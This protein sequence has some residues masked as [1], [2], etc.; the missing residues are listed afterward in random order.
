VLNPLTIF[1]MLWSVITKPEFKVLLTNVDYVQIYND[2]QDLIIV[3][4]QNP[5]NQPDTQ[6][7]TN[8]PNPQPPSAQG[9]VVALKHLSPESILT[10]HE[11][12]LSL[13]IYVDK[14]GKQKIKEA[15]K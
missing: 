13:T 15:L 5:S 9:C 11:K 3:F 14:L 1:K 2:V 6:P 7:P 8:Q 10:S 12:G 4:G